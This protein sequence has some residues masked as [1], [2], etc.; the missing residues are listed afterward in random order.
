MVALETAINDAMTIPELKAQC[1]AWQIKV[2]GNKSDLKQRLL[3]HLRDNP[4]LAEQGPAQVTDWA[5]RYRRSQSSTV[6]SAPVS[7]ASTTNDASVTQIT[8][9]ASGDAPPCT[10]VFRT[11]AY[12]GQGQKR[13]REDAKDGKDE[14][15]AQKAVQS[16][17]QPRMDT[18]S[19]L[20][21]KTASVLTNL[22]KRALDGTTDQKGLASD[23]PE[24][25]TSP[26]PA[27]LKCAKSQLQAL[28]DASAPLGF[29]VLP[30]PHHL[31]EDSLDMRRDSD[32]TL[33]NSPVALQPLDT[34]KV[35]AHVRE[36]MQAFVSDDLA[37]A[38]S[39]IQDAWHEQHDLFQDACCLPVDD[40]VVLPAPRNRPT[41]QPLSP[42]PVEP[43]VQ[44]IMFASSYNPMEAHV[45]HRQQG[46]WPQ[47]QSASNY[48]DVATVS[49]S[50]QTHWVGFFL[51]RVAGQYEAVRHAVTSLLNGQDIFA[52]ELSIRFWIQQLC[53]RDHGPFFWS[54]VLE[55]SLSVLDNTVKLAMLAG[56]CFSRVITKDGQ[57]HTVLTQTG[58]LVPPNHP[59]AALALAL[60]G[61]PDLDFLARCVRFQIN[62]D[63]QGSS[64]HLGVHKDVYS[65][66]EVHI[67]IAKRF[68][69]QTRIE[70]PCYDHI[71]QRGIA[72]PIYVSEYRYA[73]MHVDMPP[74]LRNGLCL[75]TT[76]EGYTYFVLSDTGRIIGDTEFGVPDFWQSVLA[77]DAR[78]LAV[79]FSTMVER[80]AMPCWATW[81]ERGVVHSGQESG[82]VSVVH[83]KDTIEPVREDQ[84]NAA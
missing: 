22:S 62:D 61:T 52:F 66:S 70:T 74:G 67:A 56:G 3:E 82:P 39:L 13:P 79:D 48:A 30:S 44:G 84:S 72:T 75:V 11:P 33:L 71:V 15:E 23:K 20:D 8:T 64:F 6:P 31:F 35:S 5:P 10:V 51:E 80:S 83:G 50:F 7:E 25:I 27:P 78:G 58:E 21:V 18:L 69:I 65:Q 63:E 54:V 43:R 81:D 24:P 34:L 49:S 19:P 32:M 47:T 2:S 73:V 40:S 45:F 12:K 77:C 57:E 37:L 36:Q 41:F 53:E 59:M 60:E 4:Q 68:L 42:H 9:Q 14:A 76:V 17:K 46:T 55:R 29:R 1:R 28:P 38:P 26:T 16:T